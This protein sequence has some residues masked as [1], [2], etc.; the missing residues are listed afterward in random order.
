MNEMRNVSLKEKMVAVLTD[1]NRP[2]TY[3]E[4][5]E[6]I[7]TAYPEWWVD[8]SK[9]NRN[10]S[11]ALAK[12]LSRVD[13]VQSE[14]R[15]LFSFSRIEHVEFIELTPRVLESVEDDLASFKDK[16][17]AVLKWCRRPLT[18]EEITDEIQ[19][20]YPEYWNE[21][22]SPWIGEDEVRRRL[23]VRII[24]VL[25]ENL[26]IFTANLVDDVRVR[27]GLVAPDIRI[28]EEGID[29]SHVPKEQLSLFWWTFPADQKADDPY[30]I[31]VRADVEA[32][33]RATLSSATAPYDPAIILGKF[34]HPDPVLLERA[35]HKAL[36]LRGR[37]KLN[38][39]GYSYI[40]S[41]HEEISELVKCLVN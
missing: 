23:R 32:Q 22:C 16:V 17:L 1:K 10:Q 2:M 37:V 14:H 28:T 38:A 19:K 5:I 33:V 6:D 34:D 7:T 40:E 31:E 41:T 27:V 11:D 15:E 20:M 4:L 12:L 39:Y 8:A 3:M 21:L 26:D 24:L 35:V 25:E 29:C 9:R 13:V 36:E 30:R 18:Y